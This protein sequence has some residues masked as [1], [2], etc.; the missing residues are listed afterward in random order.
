M[1]KR[2]ALLLLC[3]LLAAT[4]LA[5][6]N[7][8]PATQ[9]F[10]RWSDE[11]HVFNIS[12]ADFDESEEKVFNTYYDAN[13]DKDFYKDIAIQGE[14]FSSH[15]E[16]RPTAVVGTYSL[17]IKLLGTDRW[18]LTGKQ[19]LFAQYPDSAVRLSAEDLAK[20]R[21]SAEELAE[22]APA[23]SEDG[24]NVVLKSEIETGVIFKDTPSQTPVSSY[25]DSH[26]FYIGT[27]NHQQ[28]SFYKVETT[29]TETDKNIIATVTFDGKTE[30]S[31]E[32]KLS[33][34]NLID[35]NQLL[36][37][38]RSF[39]KSETSFQDTPS[40]QMFDPLTGTAVAATFGFGYDNPMRITDEHR[41]TTQKNVRLNIV[42]VS[43][44]GTAY[45]CQEN[46]PDTV[47]CDKMKGVDRNLFTTVRFRV[48]YL[49]YELADYTQTLWDELSYPLPT[50]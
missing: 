29:Y 36:T 13:Y 27:N 22:K 15:D 6:C 39:D 20:V 9:K 33:N 50:E 45:M 37:Y 44:A 41:E 35:G 48:G 26:G 17:S 34:A 40:V 3:L 32:Y 43:V 18:Q 25:T 2:I 19:T 1:K 11:E 10:I 31:K 24:S 12:L 30:E 5:A 46:V 8:T 47:A 38:I 23:L 4:F 42:T 7:N 14:T 21:A 28:I 16:V 49:A